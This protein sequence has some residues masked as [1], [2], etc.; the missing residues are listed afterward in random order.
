MAAISPI[1]ATETNTVFRAMALILTN[2][3]RHYVYFLSDCPDS[4]QSLNGSISPAPAIATANGR[5]LLFAYAAAVVSLPQRKSVSSIHM[6]SCQ[7]N[8]ANDSAISVHDA[9][10]AGER[11]KATGL[12]AFLGRVTGM[13]LVVKKIQQY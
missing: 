3:K 1:N 12:S 7:L 8:L 5:R 9:N 6:R 4:V 11:G 10:A 13:T 2:L